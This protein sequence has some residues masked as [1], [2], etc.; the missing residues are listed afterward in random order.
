MSPQDALDTFEKLGRAAGFLY[1][2]GRPGAIRHGD[3]KAD[4]ALRV[5]Q[6]HP[7]LQGKMN[8]IADGFCWSFLAKLEQARAL[9]E[10]EQHRGARLA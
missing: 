8:T 7:H 9:Q 5:Y 3:N 4:E 6:D 1:S 10:A 2:T